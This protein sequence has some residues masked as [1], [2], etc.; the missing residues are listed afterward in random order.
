MGWCK[1][2]NKVFTSGLDPKPLDGSAQDLFAIYGYNQL[3]YLPTRVILN[4]SSLIDLF[5]VN[6]TDDV[7][8][9][10][11]LPK[12][13]EHDGVLNSFNI[14][15]EKQKHRLKTIYDYKKADFKGLLNHIKQ[16]N[17]EECIFNQPIISQPEAITKVLTDAFSLF[18]PQK[19]FLLRVEDQPWCNSYTRLEHRRKNR[20]YQIYKAAN[21]KYLRHKNSISAN[22]EKLYEK[23]RSSANES[24][25]ANKRVKLSYY[26]TVNSTLNN[27]SI[28]SKKKNGI[29]L[30]LMKKNYFFNKFTTIW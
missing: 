5:Y 13:A 12:I 14:K 8:T 26:N 19:P 18:V 7:V 4:T 20:N 24:N 15:M 30:K 6:N 10:G 16:M 2:R 29:L 11:T 25:K 17:Y 23:S 22:Y 9:H 28:S 1:I 3:I 27:H 21:S